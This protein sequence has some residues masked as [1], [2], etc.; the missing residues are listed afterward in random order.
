MREETEPVSTVPKPLLV[1]LSLTT[2]TQKKIFDKEPIKEILT[3][4]RD[5]H[6]SF[7]VSK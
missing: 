7:E 2:R 5:V 4:N 3:S 1:F 6:T